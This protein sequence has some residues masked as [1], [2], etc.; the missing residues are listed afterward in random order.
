MKPSRTP[1][2]WSV[3]TA[4]VLVFLAQ[5]TE[6]EA[7]IERGAVV[8]SLVLQG[9]YWRLLTAMFLHGGF[10]HALLNIWALYQ[11]G[12]LFETLF[13][14]RRFLLTYFATGILAS[15]ASAMFTNGYSVGA[16]GAI[17]GILGALII[18]IRRSPMWR[19]QPWTRGITQQLM[20]WAVI[21]VVIGFTVPHI[22]NAAHLGGFAGGLLLGLIPHRVP[23]PPP[24]GLVIETEK[25]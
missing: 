14:S 25:L 20:G 5:L 1:V 8:R 9:E 22:D 15:I 19:H 17:F 18:S 2:T 13:G 7:L 3:I 24:A 23:P 6:G 16:S 11:L 4:I 12:S 10:L 21:N